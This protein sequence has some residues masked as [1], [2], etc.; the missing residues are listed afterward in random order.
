[1]LDLVTTG[2]KNIGANE[3]GKLKVHADCK[4]VSDILTLDRTKESKFTLDGGAIISKITQIEKECKIEFEHVH[5]RTKNDN[6]ES[7]H[8][9]EKS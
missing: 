2:V 1:M 8:G 9:Y 4:I 6:D 3:R 5:V 7:G